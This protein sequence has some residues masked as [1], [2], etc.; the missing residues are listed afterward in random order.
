M[1]GFNAS[2][3]FDEPSKPLIGARIDYISGDKNSADND[4]NV[5]NTV[6]GTGH[7]FLAVWIILLI[8]SAHTYGLGIMDLI[9]KVAITPIENLKATLVGHIFLQMRI[10]N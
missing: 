7:K 3:I 2:Y 10:I 8:C 4:Y 5:F 9:A 1:F 6:F